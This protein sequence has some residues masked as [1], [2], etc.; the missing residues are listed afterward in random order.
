MDLAR[1]V[2]KNFAD[3][4]PQLQRAARFV[5]DHPDEVATRSLRQV[6][7]QSGLSP[8][9]YSRL[10][11]AIGFEQYEILRDKCRE[12]LK[13][14]QLTLAERAALA[15]SGGASLSNPARGSFAAR[16]TSTV[17]N[18]LNTMVADLDTDELADVVNLLATAGSVKLVGVL[19]GRIMVDYMAHIAGLISPNWSVIG[20]DAM[21]VANDLADIGRDTV[22]L[23]VSV[24][25]YSSR[26]AQLIDIAAKAGAT[27]I[28]ITDDMRSPFI[29]AS[30]HS[31][32][33]PTNSL[34]HF[35]S[36]TA[37]LTLLEI[38]GG[39]VVRRLDDGASKRIDKVEKLSRLVG[40]YLE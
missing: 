26:S 24:A 7:K 19:S 35:P 38:V 5:I 11:R 33:V 40:D 39:M 8:P 16:H 1:Q 15:Q 34:N 32:L 18:S 2:S 29:A 14:K 12:E 25:P 31:F 22:V 23:A 20:G 27:V 17:V 37:I 10:A 21:S 6:A 4:S 9:T 28:A 3:L 13:Q 30:D 36:H